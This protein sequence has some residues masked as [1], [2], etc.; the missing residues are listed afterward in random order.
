MITNKTK[1]KMN[2]VRKNPRRPTTSI[3][4]IIEKIIENEIKIGIRYEANGNAIVVTSFLLM[5]LIAATYR[6]NDKAINSN[7]IR[8]E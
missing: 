8:R 2:G 6:N 7:I 4:T 3:D 1:L 5:I